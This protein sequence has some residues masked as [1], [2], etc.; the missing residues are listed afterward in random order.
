MFSRHKLKF[1]KTDLSTFNDCVICIFVVVVVVIIVVIFFWL[2]LF[3][4]LLLSF[5]A[6]VS[7]LATH[8]I[9]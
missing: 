9:L 2:L 5:L 7:V 1:N 6:F 4:L 3:L 8:F